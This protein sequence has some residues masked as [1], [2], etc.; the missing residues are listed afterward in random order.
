MISRLNGAFLRLATPRASRRGLETVEW[1]L[2]G[3]AVVLVA[4]FAYQL[5]GQEMVD[6][7]GRLTDGVSEGN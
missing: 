5:L 3:V 1:V 4:F 7:I 6:F 2:V